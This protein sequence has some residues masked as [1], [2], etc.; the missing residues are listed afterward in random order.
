MSTEVVEPKTAVQLNRQFEDKS[1]VNTQDQ[2]FNI[3]DENPVL[4]VKNLNLFY[5]E[6]QALF[7]VNMVI[8]ERRVTAFIGP[9][10]CGKSTLGKCIVGL[11]KPNAGE[12]L[13]QGK[14]I[15]NLSR[16][17]IRMWQCVSCMTNSRFWTIMKVWMYRDCR[18]NWN[19]RIRWP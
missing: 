16:A 8:P 6:K 9:S 11:E 10:G 19:Q 3:L 7:D 4:E 5:G 15:L 12:I 17:K 2:N 1:K 13:Y 14:D 18:E